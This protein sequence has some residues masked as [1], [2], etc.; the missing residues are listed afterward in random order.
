[1]KARQGVTRREL[2][3]AGAVL[4]AG[5]VCGPSR[6]ADADQHETWSIGNALIRRDVAYAPG[7]G[8]YTT[9]IAD[10]AAGTNL[11]GAVSD[12]RALAAEFSLICDGQECRS[13]GGVFQL[14]DT[15]EDSGEGKRTRAV[16]LRHIKLPLEVRAVYSVYDGHAAIR[17][18]LVLK[19]T[20][21]APLK[22]THLQIDNLAFALGPENEMTL[23]AQYGAVPREIFY[24]G[25][26]ED[27]GLMLANG[28]TGAGVTV[29]NEAPGYMKRTEVAGWDAPDSVRV[30]AMYD[31]DLM[32]FERRLAPG[33]ELTTASA[34]LIPFRR[35]DA[36]NDPRWRVPGYTA[37]VLER[38][39]DQGGPPWIYNT[40]EPF[41]RGI[42]QQISMDLI[43]AAG[44]MG[45][46]VFTIDDGWQQEYGDNA[47]NLA[48]FPGGLDP[49]LKAVESRGMRLG[50][51]IPPA[52]IGMTTEVY[53]AHPEWASRDID[54]NVKTTGTM[55]GQKVV[56]CMASRFCMSAAER[57]NDAIERFRL[58]YAKLDLTTIFNAYGEA[59]GCWAKGHD[60]ADW[61]ES[62]HRIYEGIREM[63]SAVYAK[64]P[65]VLLDLTFE[66]WGQKH[67]I[68]AGLLAAGDLDWM[69]NVDDRHPDAAGPL[70]AR[71]L[72]YARAAS[73]PVEAMLIG[74]MH[75]E[76]P[77][78]QESFATAIGSAPLLLGD[79]RKL[80]AADRAWY[81]EKIRW[82]KEL[83]KSVKL[84]DSFFPLGSWRQTSPAA[85]DGFA[86]LA[87]SGEGVVAVFRNKSG[88]AGARVELPLIPEGR[89][90]VRVVISGK[91]L[92]TFDRSAWARGVDVPFAGP[93]EVLEMKRA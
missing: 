42:N 58:A 62:L 67:I 83:R 72:L 69:S 14:V 24:T 25:R 84:S 86:R 53:K 1:M 91:V 17:K 36:F 31:T 68:D 46:D 80:S 47:V 2:L 64:H 60:H 93:A 71:Q 12:A 27:A 43:E 65:D 92:G 75:A 34:S 22:I 40:W 19:N 6:L 8:L 88:V 7:V 41:E 70:Q 38:R 52:A 54:G 35:G 29:L 13:N 37:A 85:W 76:L 44:A 9:Q 81:G 20:G 4:A 21:T 56:M 49:I 45:M 59:P 39:V 78:I 82:F 26:S 15:R 57:I 50:L 66:L 23:L 73:M 5:V 74:N 79:L 90:R 10:L 28:R 3:Q 77:T 61:A 87:R 48:A 16:R 30:S 51:W 18:H 33:E 89:Y 63:T 32:P 55:A 11:L